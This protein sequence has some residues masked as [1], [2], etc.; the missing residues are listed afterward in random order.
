MVS[1]S[2]VTI[3]IFMYYAGMAWYWIAADVALIIF[4]LYVVLK[5]VA[6]KKKKVVKTIFGR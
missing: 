3:A 6:S 5:I 4:L 2:F 1:P